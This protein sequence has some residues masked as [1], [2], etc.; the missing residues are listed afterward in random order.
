VKTK[1]SKIAVILLLLA[2]YFSSCKEH[3]PGFPEHL[4]D[5]FPYKKG[6]TLSFVNQHDDIVCFRVSNVNVNEERSKSSCGKCSCGTYRTYYEIIPVTEQQ[7]MQGIQIT[8]SVGG[9]KPYIF[10]NLFN[11]YPLKTSTFIFEEETGKNPFDP[12]N[13]A[14]FGDSIVIV[15]ENQLISK[16]IIVKGKGITVFY[17]QVQDCQWEN[18][19]INN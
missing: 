9:T 11:C 10:L 6:E 15:D 16:V 3:C 4:V 13:S 8:V 18:I 14:L 17:D 7:C 5:Y 19:E 12:K 1:I 2:G